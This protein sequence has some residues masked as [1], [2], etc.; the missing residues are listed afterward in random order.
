MVWVQCY[1]S[2]EGL[3]P[4]KAEG[5]SAE[6]SFSNIAMS[7]QDVFRFAVRAVPAVGLLLLHLHSAAWHDQALT[8]LQPVASLVRSNRLQR[9]AEFLRQ[10]ASSSQSSHKAYKAGKGSMQEGNREGGPGGKGGPGGGGGMQSAICR[11]GLHGSERL[12]QCCG[13]SS[14]STTTSSINS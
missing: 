2:Q 4:L 10:S 9:P 14:T 3:K 8:S 12:T 6:G 13:I 11:C 5:A 7:G 1:F